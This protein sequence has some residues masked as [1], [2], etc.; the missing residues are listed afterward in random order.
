VRS[1]LICHHDDPLNRQGLAAWL[2]SF[3]DLVGLIVIRESKGRV[4]RRVR[5]ELRRVGVLRFP[6]VVGFRAYYRLFL[7]SRDQR[8]ERRRLAQL[9][10]RYGYPPVT[11]RVV[12][13][14]DPNAKAVEIAIRELAPEVMIARCKTLL[15]PSVFRI[16]TRGTFVM[17]PGI[18]PEYRNA[19][20]CFWA[21]A[22][23]DRGNVGMTLLKIDD[24]VDTGPVYA[25]FRCDA[26]DV[27]ESHIV[28]QHR[29]VLD[30]LEALKSKLLEI[31][32]NRAQPLD[33]SDRPSRVWGQPWLT[34]YLTWKIKARWAR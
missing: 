9:T 13:T 18:C 1:V 21:L 28:I 4:A 27:D 25:Y 15:K 23:G 31:G 10:E 12:E 33:T 29:T 26:H 24:G 8:W 34:A 22:R 19:H 5:R 7:L 20:G 17:H 2:A 11:T 14:A 30:N 3:S 16:P 32:E 6:D